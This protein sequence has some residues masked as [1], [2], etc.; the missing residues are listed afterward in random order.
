M[1]ILVRTFEEDNLSFEF[2]EKHESTIKKYENLIYKSINLKKSNLN[3]IKESIKILNDSIQAYYDLKKYC[4][5]YKGGIIY[6]QDVWEHC[7]NTHNSDFAYV[8]NLETAKNY[9]LDLYV[10]MKGSN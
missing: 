10:K 2:E 9:Y 6:F 8:E 5:K 7:H 1:I 4:Y 3:E